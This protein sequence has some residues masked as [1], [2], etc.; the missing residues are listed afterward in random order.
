MPWKI[1]KTS[2]RTRVVL[3]RDN[4]DKLMI[5]C[6]Y[7]YARF[8]TARIRLILKGDITKISNACDRINIPYI[9]KTLL[10]IFQEILTTGSIYFRGLKF[11]EKH[12]TPW[13]NIWT[14]NHTSAVSMNV[15]LT[16]SLS[17]LTCMLINIIK[18]VIYQ[19]VILRHCYWTMFLSTTKACYI[20]LNSTTLLI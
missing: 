10:T 15:N 13:I 6:N 5:R 9:T 12:I 11:H 8:L 1:S 4:R 19:I 20:L 16:R 18:L 3:Y 7:T 2:E 17:I 14:L